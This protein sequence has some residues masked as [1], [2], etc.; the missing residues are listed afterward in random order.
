MNYL[1]GYIYLMIQDEEKA[2]KAFSNLMQ[3]RM[4]SVFINSFDNLK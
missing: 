3:N 1:A 4:K 2:Y